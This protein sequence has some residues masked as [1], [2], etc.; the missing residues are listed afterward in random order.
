VRGASRLLRFA[1]DLAGL[2]R[3][4]LGRDLGS[5][6]TVAAVSVPQGMAYALV[7]GLPLEM[8]LLAAGLPAL[9][10][11]LFGSSPYLITGPTNPTALVISASVVAPAIAAGHGVPIPQVLA[12]GMIAG[13]LLMGF[14]WARVG[15]ASRFLA[16]SV[17]R[18]L[19]VAVGVLVVLGQLAAAT[20]LSR[21]PEPASPLIPQI[22]PLLVDTLRS[23]LA[24]DLRTLLLL[25]GVPVVVAAL[26]GLDERWPGG[27]LALGGA[28]AL[29]AALGWDRGPDALPGLAAAASIWPGLVLPGSLDA[30]LGAPALAIALLVTAQSLGAARSM[31]GPRVDFDRELF[32]QGAANVTAALIGAMP[33]SGSFTRSAVARRSGARSRAAA[34]TSGVAVLLLLPVL[35]DAITRIP[36]AALAGLVLL[37]G[38]DLVNLPG[39]R[40]ACTTSGD[41]WVLGVTFGTALWLGIVEA[42]YAGLF[43][44][45]AL[46]VRRSGRLQMVEIVR[47]G[48]QRV[49]EIAIDERTGSTPAVVLHLEGDLN[50]AVA[51]DLADQL[52]AIGARGPR[53]LILR[54]KRAR[55]LDATVLDALRRVFGELVEKGVTPMLCGL[56][57]RTATSLART[58]VG[59]L[60]GPDGLLETGPRLF[61]GLERAYSRARTLLAPLDDSEIFR[62]EQPDAWSY[63][64]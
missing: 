43:L 3:A 13:V 1:P 21:S 24:L 54:L 58:E 15:S 30:E 7:A 49:R 55:H 22:W 10:A 52:R 16:D 23:L 36:L 34:A 51:G 46:L 14:A 18:G 25:M 62:D 33:T 20:G 37:T 27:I 59:R 64:I 38:I 63:E 44:S 56:D 47:A 40:R 39:I 32:G 28:A 57:R 35:G 2:S 61:E 9:V 31:P 4:G 19:S 11:A 8:G 6:L 48:R 5:G 26:R 53:V 17:V 60:L 42:I 41:S 12:I 45:L 29:S 50:F